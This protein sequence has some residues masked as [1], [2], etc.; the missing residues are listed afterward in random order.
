MIA[1][2]APEWPAAVSVAG[3]IAL[4]GGLVAILRYLEKKEGR[5]ARKIPLELEM[6]V[7]NQIVVEG[8]REVK[9]FLRVFWPCLIFYS[10]VLGP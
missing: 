2:E 3:F 8:D 7:L 6:K 10:S 4:C 1:S 9:V 5:A